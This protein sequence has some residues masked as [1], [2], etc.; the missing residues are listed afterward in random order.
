[1]RSRGQTRGDSRQAGPQPAMEAAGAEEPVQ[2]GQAAAQLSSSGLLSLASLLLGCSQVLAQV[3]VQPRLGAASAVPRAAE[4]TGELPRGRSARLGWRCRPR[5]H[6]VAE[7]LRAANALRPARLP[8]LILLSVHPLTE[9]RVPGHVDRVQRLAALGAPS[10]EVP[11]ALRD[12][13]RAHLMATGPQP[14]QPPPWHVLR[15]PEAHGALPALA[16]DPLLDLQRLRRVALQVL[17]VAGRARGDGVLVGAAPAVIA[18]ILP[19]QL[20]PK[21]RPGRRGLV[22]ARAGLHVRIRA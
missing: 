11:D 7:R 1:M 22:A 3:P 5:N 17:L 20:P 18:L 2:H 8:H 13:L 14:V 16:A 9:A 10:A 12:A 21:P 4:A 19:L 15:A 6:A